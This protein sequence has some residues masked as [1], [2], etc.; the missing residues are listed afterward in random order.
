MNNNYDRE[1]IPVEGKIGIFR[2]SSNTAILNTNSNDYHEYLRKKNVLLKKEEKI[3][4]TSSEIENVKNEV[5][6]IKSEVSEIKSLLKQLIEQ[7]K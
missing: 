1:L 5:N 3:N 2:D 7:S 6:Q 4:N